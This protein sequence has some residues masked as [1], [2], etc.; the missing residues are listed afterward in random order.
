MDVPEAGGG[1]LGAPDPAA[2]QLVSEKPRRRRLRAVAATVLALV[3]VGV[4]CAVAVYMVAGRGSG[5][6]LAK[7]VPA[8]VDVYATALLDPSLG[9]K[10]NLQSVLQHF[11]GMHDAGS[12]TKTVTDTLDKA[13]HDAGFDYTHDISPWLGSQVA[14]VA[15]LGDKPDGAWLARSSDDAAAERALQKAGSSMSKA[16]MSWSTET[17]NGVIVHVG[18]PPATGS[19]AATPAAAYAVFNH[20]A[21]VGSATSLVHRIIDTS[22]GGAA[23]SSS[24]SYTATLEKLPDDHLG[25]VYVNAAGLIATIKHSLGASFAAKLPADMQQSWDQL[26]AYRSFGMSV[27]AESD[28]VSSDWVTLTDPSKLSDTARQQLA[29]VPRPLDSLSWVPQ[30]SYGV[31]AWSGG[32]TST[33]SFSAVLGAMAGLTVIGRQVDS[34]AAPSVQKGLLVPPPSSSSAAVDPFSALQGLSAPGGLTSHLTGGALAVGPGDGGA[35]VSVVATLQ[36]DGSPDVAPQ[37]EILFDGLTGGTRAALDATFCNIANG[38]NQGGGLAPLPPGSQCPTA[39]PKLPQWQTTHE[40]GVDVHYLGSA[41]ANP[42]PAYAVVGGTVVIGSSVTTVAHAVTG[43][44]SG[45]SITGQPAFHSSDA[46]NALGGV[47]FVDLQ[48][49]VGAVDSSLSGA[50]KSSFDSN[51]LPNLRPLRVFTV[52]SSSTISEQRIH[53]V[54]TVGG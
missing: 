6:Q 28:A 36:T 4:P 3:V 27:Q 26:D 19:G 16:T 23:L 1:P 53:M 18:T 10:R 31:V 32:N 38:I 13:L 8:D 51:A 25:V 12:I 45:M 21:V 24:P 11:P 46:A 29:G 5:D 52:T 33:P 7:L 49:V 22:K 40:G 20:V 44:S 17:Y 9:Q 42:T 43:H 48:R 30:D 41:T 50:D 39:K 54:L 14:V 2:D 15:T 34:S 37:L 47:F 35:P